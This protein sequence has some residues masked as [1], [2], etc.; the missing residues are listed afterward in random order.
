MGAAHGVCYRWITVPQG[1]NIMAISCW[2][3]TDALD[4]SSAPE[5]QQIKLYFQYAQARSPQLEA[6]S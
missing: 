6:R 4:K 3:V 2:H 1:I 5:P